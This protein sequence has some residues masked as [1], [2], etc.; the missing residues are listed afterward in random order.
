MD[1]FRDLDTA[2]AAV[3]RS[4]LSGA[5]ET[6]SCQPLVPVEQGRSLLSPDINV[7]T[8]GVLNLHSKELY[9]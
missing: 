4:F 1:V 3:P 7:H 6:Y 2:L 8:S 5:M 9:L